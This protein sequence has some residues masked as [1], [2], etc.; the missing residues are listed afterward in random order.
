MLNVVAQD[1]LTDVSVCAVI[2]LG[3]VNADNREA[4]FIFLFLGTSG[5]DG[6]LQVNTAV[7]QKSRITT[8]PL[9]CCE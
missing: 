5:S 9:S 1:S 6:T 7:G 4:V 2:K 3:R 8:L